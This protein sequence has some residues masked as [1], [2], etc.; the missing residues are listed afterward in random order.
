LRKASTA[1]VV[2]PGRCLKG[3][4]GALAE[5]VGPGGLGGRPEGARW[6]GRDAPVVQ[7]LKAADAIPIGRT[8]LQTC[9]VGWVCESELYEATANPWDRSWTQ[10]ASSG[11]KAAAL[12]TGMTP[13]GL[14]NDGFG[15]LRWPAQCCGIATLRPTVGRIPTRPP[16]T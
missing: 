12:A 3:S 2:R 7:Q 5:P 14:G 13:L 8:N 9:G 11:G 10:G 4:A 15:S 6:P 1:F 16:S